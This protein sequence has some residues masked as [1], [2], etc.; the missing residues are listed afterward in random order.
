MVRNCRS[1][2][3]KSKKRDLDEKSLQAFTTVENPNGR[4]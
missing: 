4:T 1:Y 3:R 2:K